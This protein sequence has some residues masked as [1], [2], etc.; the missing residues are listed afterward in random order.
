METAV[1]VGAGLKAIAAARMLVDRGFRV[2]LV[3]KAC[4]KMLLAPAADLSATAFSALPV[5]RLKLT[6][7]KTAE[8]AEAI[9]GARRRASALECRRPD[10]I[11]EGLCRRLSG[12]RAE[13]CRR[14]DG[15]LRQNR[16]AAPPGS[17]RRCQTWR[18]RRGADVA[19]GSLPEHRKVLKAAASYRFPTTA[20]AAAAASLVGRMSNMPAVLLSDEFDFGKSAS[21]RGI[22][23]LLVRAGC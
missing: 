6:C 14:T 23:R 12:P 11:F 8:F 18:R 13:S 10:A 7:D 1:V 20:F 15:G 22:E 3:E 17:R 5:R 9:A 4:G 21:V 19:T 16:C 2:T